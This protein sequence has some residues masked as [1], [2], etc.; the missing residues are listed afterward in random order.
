MKQLIFKSLIW[1][2]YQYVKCN[3]KFKLWINQFKLIYF[4]KTINSRKN[5]LQIQ[6]LLEQKSKNIKDNI[7]NLSNYI[8]KIISNISKPFISCEDCKQE[9]KGFF[10]YILL[11]RVFI[12]YYSWQMSIKNEKKF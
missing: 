9:K 6:K 1:N 5:Y 12:S 3:Y 2:K 10:I 8:N 7:N 4:F 11:Q